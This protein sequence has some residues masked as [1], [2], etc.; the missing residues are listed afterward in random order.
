M[1][2]KRNFKSVKKNREAFNT[3]PMSDLRKAMTDGTQRNAFTK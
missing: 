3:Q 2:N 1:A